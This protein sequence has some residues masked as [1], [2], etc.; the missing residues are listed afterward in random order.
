MMETNRAY[1]KRWPRKNLGELVNFLEE[2]HP[3]GLSLQAVA[4]RLGVQRGAVSNMFRRDDMHL[5]GAAAIARKY[6]YELTILFPERDLG[7][8]YVPTPPRIR[9]N[10]AGMLTGLVKYI[11]DSEY[12]ISFVAER[13]HVT[14]NTV[15]RAFRTGDI[16]I[17]MLNTM[18]DALG[19]CALWKFEKIK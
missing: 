5:S 14:A 18:L 2:R 11:Q 16:M 13:M 9:Y 17:S 15:H 4:D 8:G 12:S 19:I 7:I 6:G 1:N 10:E 3:E